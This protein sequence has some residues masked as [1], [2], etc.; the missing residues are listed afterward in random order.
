MK[1]DEKDRKILALLTQ[2]A[3]IPI[4]E[5]ARNVHLARTTVQERIARL[6][7][8]NIIK[9]YTTIVSHSSDEPDRLTVLVRLNVETKEFD[10]VVSQLQQLP[11]VTRCAAISGSADLFLELNVS[12]VTKLEQLLALLGSIKGVNQ[13]D[14]NIVL[15]SYFQR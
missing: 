1:L 11:D 9:G 15:N 10:D 7:D 13:T 8:K 2:D 6:Q 4:A 5:L 14:S 12:N 3:R